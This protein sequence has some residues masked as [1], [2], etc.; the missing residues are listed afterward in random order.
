MPKKLRLHFYDLERQIIQYL[1]WDKSSPVV[2][3]IAEILEKQ[4]AS[5]EGGRDDDSPQEEE[6]LQEMTVRESRERALL[7][8]YN[9]FFARVLNIAAESLFDLCQRIGIT[10]EISEIIWCVVKVLLSQETDLLV[11]RHLD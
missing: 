3:K 8:P 7:R 11:N 9:V 1:S 6:G 5:L 10:D 2:Q 4:K